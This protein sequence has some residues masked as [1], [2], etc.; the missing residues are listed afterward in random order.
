[1]K[2]L[3][4]RYKVATGDPHRPLRRRNRALFLFIR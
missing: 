1:M 3:A 4:Y 2:R